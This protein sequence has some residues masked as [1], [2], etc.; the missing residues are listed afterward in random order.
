MRAVGPGHPEF[1]PCSDEIIRGTAA[2][3]ARASTRRKS[4]VEGSIQCTSSTHKHDRLHAGAAGY[5]ARERSDEAAPPLLGRVGRW[6]VE[7]AGTG[8]S[9]S[10]ATSGT[11]CAGSR[12]T[13]RCH[14]ANAATRRSGVASCS[15]S[16]R[17][18][19]SMNGWYGVFLQQLRT[20][21][22]DPGV[23]KL[24]DPALELLCHP[25]FAKSGLAD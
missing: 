14:A 16:R 1:G 4:S 9:S 15:S 8:S 25:R 3:S 10:G 22:L 7:S 13:A 12:P 5:P 24:C 23:W 2:P 11:D 17:R 21:K 20:C 19:N 18:A 6:R